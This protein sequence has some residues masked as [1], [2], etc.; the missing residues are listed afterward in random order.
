MFSITTAMLSRANLVHDVGFLEHGNTSCL[1]MVVMAD[2][3]VRMSRFFTE[4]IA[5]DDRTLALDA[6][7]RVARSSSGA[8]FL[9]DDHTFEHFMKA[10]FLPV[11]IDR[12]RYDSWLADGGLD[13]Y[14]RCNISAKRLLSTHQVRPKDNQLLK[15]IDEILQRH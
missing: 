14:R 9:T 7:D 11:L 3:L 5:V 15:G 10:Q 6:I 2:E 4:G 8:I 12:A 13:M 1:E